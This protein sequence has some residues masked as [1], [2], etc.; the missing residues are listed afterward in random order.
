MLR[1]FKKNSWK[2]KKKKKVQDWPVQDWP[3][4]PRTHRQ[5]IGEPEV[6][7]PV[8]V[9]NYKTVHASLSVVNFHRSAAVERCREPRLKKNKNKKKSEPR[10]FFTGLTR[11]IIYRRFMGY[12]RR[13]S[14]LEQHTINVS[15]FSSN[16]LRYR[17]SADAKPCREPRLKKRNRRIGIKL[18]VHRW[19]I[20]KVVYRQFIGL[21]MIPLPIGP[22]HWK[23]ARAS[24]SFI[25]FGSLLLQSALMG[26]G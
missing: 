14:L 17:S 21:L 13:H 1:S 16:I 25:F 15:M 20:Y 8:G 11:I 5:F 18:L 22:A 7:L 4:S 24:L 10:V 3:L 26:H 6:P 12:P 9:T 19:C 23:R 2:K